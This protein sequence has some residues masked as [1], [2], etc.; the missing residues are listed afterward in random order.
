MDEFEID[1]I[2]SVDR[3]AQTPAEALIIKN[4]STSKESD[5]DDEKDPAKSP[6]KNFDGKAGDSKNKMKKTAEEKTAERMDELEKRALKA[7]QLATLTDIQK[8]HYGGLSAD[9][10]ATYLGDTPEARQ[11]AVEKAAGEDPVVYT[12]LAGEDIR[13]SDG[14]L[15]IGLAKRADDSEKALAVEKAAREHDTFSKR[16][17]SE[18]SNL[19]GDKSV[20]VAL[21]KAIDGIPNVEDQKGALEIMKAA[22]EGV[23]KAFE[24]AGTKDGG[25][26]TGSEAADKIVKLANER[27]AANGEPYAKAFLAVLNSSEGREL[28]KQ[29]RA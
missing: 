6:G 10:Q 28:Y 19:P 16:A 2:S 12:T 8:A 1:E 15:L 22:N 17:E 5:D 11:A 20:Q 3:P 23:S 24:S 13:K 9:S 4:T 18:L 25:S 14:T 21:L 29:S 7:E 27:S 26:N